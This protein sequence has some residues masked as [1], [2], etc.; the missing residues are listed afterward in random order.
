[1]NNSS[2]FVLNLVTQM[3][4]MGVNIV[5]GILIIPFLIRALG[6][7]GYSL[8]VL[9]VSIF[10]FASL[11]EL[12]IGT[13]IQRFFSICLANGDE[14][15]FNR[16][17]STSLMIGVG[18]FAIVM[19]LCTVFSRQIME[20]CNAPVQML[21]VASL[22][23][24]INMSHS[25][26]GAFIVPIYRSIYAS[27][28][29][30]DLI[31]YIFTGSKI[32]QVVLW[33]FVLKYTDTG[34]LG[35]SSSNLAVTVLLMLVIYFG[36][37]KLVPFLRFS[38]GSF[39]I[40]ALKS[41]Y[42]MGWRLSIIR[43]SLF[44]SNSL[45][46]FMLSVFGNLLANTVFQPAMK[47]SDLFSQYLGFIGD[48]LAPH[49]STSYANR[50]SDTMKNIYLTG[51]RIAF[52][53]I[54]V[55]FC[56]FAF[57]GRDI[58][59]IWLESTLPDKYEEVYYAFMLITFGFLCNATGY[60]QWAVIL[61]L[62]R[63][64]FLAVFHILRVVFIM[65]FS[66]VLLKYTDLG[67]YAVI[68]PSVAMRIASTVAISAYLGG[69]LK[70][71]LMQQVF[72]SYLNGILTLGFL[73]PILVVYMVYLSFSGYGLVSLSANVGISV[74]IAMPVMWFVG[75]NSGDRSRIVAMAGM[76][77]SKIKASK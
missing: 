9:Y 12:G 59:H 23:F 46:P 19:A 68:L 1:M 3:G 36:S 76:I 52:S 34:I 43:L 29:R 45:S 14:S 20:L 44:I 54:A 69:E 16:F 40:S 37:Q 5:L 2:R 10:G 51:T 61:A 55:G 25:G 75:F 24:V 11:L 72:Q 33:Y 58:F 53:S 70:V 42:S 47:A 21:D 71:S 66:I 27:R 74:L 62:G 30:F 50:D 6:H 41:I 18:A 60:I 57:W 22:A 48:Q 64:N 26:V 31:S 35:W 17:Y 4:T 13:S 67:V 63:L 15:R 73:A 49:A 7:E 38:F 77:I 39:D 8:S 56:I 28:H 65:F 32:L